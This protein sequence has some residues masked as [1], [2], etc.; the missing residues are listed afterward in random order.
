MAGRADDT[1]KVERTSD[2]EMTVTRRFNAPARIVFAAWSRPELFQRW[3]A[4]RSSGVPL[5]SCEMDVR[6]GGSYRLVFG[7]D[8]AQSM[9]FFGRY[10]EVTPPARIV[11]TNEESAEGAVT[12][13]TFTEQDGQTLLVLREAYPSKEALDLSIEG[14]EGGMPEQF[15]QL[16]ELLEALGG[17]LE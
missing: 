7:R 8:A 4:P 3:W 1:T 5:L 10:I 15:A 6:T 9:A 2:R 11:W 17:K 13:V 16:D 12:T 14:M